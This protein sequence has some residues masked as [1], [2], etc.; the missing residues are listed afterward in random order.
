MKP[1][2]QATTQQSENDRWRI[3]LF[4]ADFNSQHTYGLNASPNK[5]RLKQV[6][7]LF[8]KLS[9]I[10]SMHTHCLA[11]QINFVK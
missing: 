8:R 11:L 9:A 7:L 5:L 4:L 10:T 2:R 6:L 3:K 1:L